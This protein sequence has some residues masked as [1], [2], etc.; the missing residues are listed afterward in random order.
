MSRPLSPV[1]ARPMTPSDDE[2]DVEEPL[3]DQQPQ[4]AKSGNAARC[5][6]AADKRKA[7]MGDEAFRKANA[8]RVA[9]CRAAKKGLQYGLRHVLAPAERA[10][11]AVVAQPLTDADRAALRLPALTQPSDAD[12]GGLKL[13]LRAPAALV[14]RPMTPSDEDSDDDA[15][16]VT[17]GEVTFVSFSDVTHA[18]A[19]RRRPRLGRERQ[20]D[21]GF[22]VRTTRWACWRLSLP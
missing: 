8:E 1:V 18:L 20:G 14:A 4:P 11:E 9:R 19:G 2:D 12:G 13:F 5:K 7:K 3:P 6:R 17:S 21:E 22:G 10:G 16:C 15:A